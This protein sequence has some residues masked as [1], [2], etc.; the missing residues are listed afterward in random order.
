MVSR[1][2]TSPSISLA[3]VRKGLFTHEDVFNVHKMLG[4]RGQR[5]P[6]PGPRQSAV[7]TVAPQRGPARVQRLPGGRVGRSCAH[8]CKSTPELAARDGQANGRVVGCLFVY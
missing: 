3:A 6:A 2:A 5:K 8:G 7:R 4:L 1:M